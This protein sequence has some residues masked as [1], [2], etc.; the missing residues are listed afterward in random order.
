M[1][2]SGTHLELGTE[3]GTV[4]AA[5]PALGSRF[6]AT[7]ALNGTSRAARFAGVQGSERRT[8]AVVDW[9]LMTAAL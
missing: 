4:N 2:L 3:I 9:W 1:T 5:G 7:P 8:S 6:A